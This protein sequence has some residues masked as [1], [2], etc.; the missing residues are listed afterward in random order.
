MKLDLKF[1]YHQIRVQ[2]EDVPKTAFRTHDGHYEYLVM[3]FGLTNA[4][5]TFQS[6]M[7]DI[8]QDLLQR[9]VLVFF[10]DILVYNKNWDAHLSHLATVLGTLMKD[11]L[12]VNQ[13]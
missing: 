12:F 10:D 11:Q 7:N 8:F 5:A 3:P 6:L 13:S 1:G 9:Y 2:L 4:L